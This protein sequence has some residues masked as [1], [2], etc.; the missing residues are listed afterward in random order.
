WWVF[1]PSDNEQT[2][3]KG[4]EVMVLLPLY[5]C[6]INLG[7]KLLSL[8]VNLSSSALSLPHRHQSYNLPSKGRYDFIKVTISDALRQSIVNSNR[9]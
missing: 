2:T 6:P 8:A 3:K 5:Y 9:L 1:R 7:S 4:Q